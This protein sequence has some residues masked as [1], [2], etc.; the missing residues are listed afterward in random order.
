MSAP[1]LELD[2][3]IAELGIDSLMTVELGSMIE[4]DLGVKVPAMEAM[5]GSLTTIAHRVLALLGLGEG[6]ASPAAAVAAEKTSSGITI[7]RPAPA[8]N[9]L[10]KLIAIPY[11][12]GS[13]SAFASWPAKLGSEIELLSVQPA[14]RDGGAVDGL[15]RSISSMVADLGSKLVGELG[16]PYA[17]YGHSL[18]ATIAFELA[19]WLRAADAP[20]PAHLFI[21][22]MSAPQL[23][24]QLARAFEAWPEDIFERASE[25]LWAETLHMVIPRTILEDP[26]LLKAMLPVLKAEFAMVREYEYRPD[27]PLDCPITCFAGSEDPPIAIES[28][29]QWEAQTTGAFG[30]HVVSGDHLFLRSQAEFITGVIRKSL[31]TNSAIETKGAAEI[32]LGGTLA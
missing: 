12:A 29:K 32:E 14:G 3:P 28:M 7:L 9:V 26:A 20:P 2:K 8:R 16:R 5:D 30:L 31:Q 4:D 22:A 24:N 17:F 19:R 21:G 15:H 11:T 10:L 18:G 23:P 1:Q 6:D 27:G 13:G 25:T